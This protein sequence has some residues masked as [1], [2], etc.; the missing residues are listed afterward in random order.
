MIAS[1]KPAHWA[2][3]TGP[4][5]RAVVGSTRARLREPLV[6]ASGPRMTMETRVLTDIARGV[7][8]I[9]AV[10]AAAMQSGVGIG[11]STSHPAPQPTAR[12][13]LGVPNRRALRCRWSCAGAPSS[14]M[15]DRRARTVGTGSCNC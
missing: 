5:F 11:E 9:P 7:R 15:L 2:S 10:I 14:E 6:V 3:P 4:V 8:A 1:T 13:R 12:A